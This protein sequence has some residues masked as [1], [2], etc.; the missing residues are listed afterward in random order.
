MKIQKQ[1]HHLWLVTWNDVIFSKIVNHLVV[2]ACILPKLDE[3]HN[4]QALKLKEHYHFVFSYKVD[5]FPKL[6][7]GFMRPKS[8]RW[9]RTL[10]NTRKWYFMMQGIFPYPSSEQFNHLPTLFGYSEFDWMGTRNYRTPCTL[11]VKKW[12]NLKPNCIELS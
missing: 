1:D 8:I 9:F 5:P 12:S 10:T 3:I 6:L 7:S 2:R 4:L 11:H